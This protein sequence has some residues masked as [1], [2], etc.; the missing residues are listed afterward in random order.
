MT[1]GLKEKINSLPKKP[2]VYLFKDSKGRVIYVG[3]SVSLR[4]RVSSYFSDI[5][6]GE[7][8][9]L[10]VKNIYDLSFIEVENELEALL[11]ESELIKRKKPRFNISLKDDK[12][13]KFIVIKN[14]KIEGINY[15]VV[16]TARKVDEKKD[17][18]FGPFPEGRT[19][20]EVMR[21]VR[22]I[23]PFRDCSLSKFKKY[24]KIGSP[25]LYGHIGLCPAPCVGRVTGVEYR[26]IVLSLRKLLS[27]NSKNLIRELGAEMKAAANNKDFE[28]AAFYRDQIKKYEYVTQE[29]RS[30]SSYVDNPNLMEDKRKKSLEDLVN[31]I[32]ILSKAP[33]RIECYDISNISGK[34][35][36]A[37]MVVANSG[38]LQRGEYKRFRIRSKETPDDFWMV[39]EV[40]RRR[41]NKTH[42]NWKVPDLIVIDG[43]KGQV[44]SA[45]G[46]LD[47]FGL[48]ISVIGLAKRFEHVIY[49]DGDTFKELNLGPDNSGLKLLQQMRDEAHR[50][51]KRYHHFLRIKSLGIKN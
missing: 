25:C 33:L 38:G 51:A 5:V 21:A 34:D 13:F 28:K 9:R 36:T 17:I 50:F 49:N 43:G 47:E 8:T 6:D 44:G 46:I 1:E 48:E 42:S 15:P 32:S 3:K 14:E 30:T 16:K 18:F 40:L 39:R 26:K 2:G 27:G 29:F 23:I 4:D 45:N 10:L 37:S 35:A 11:L 12:S 31:A 24:R 41:F 20:N 22:K 7:K 19:V